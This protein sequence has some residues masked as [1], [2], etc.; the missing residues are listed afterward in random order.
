MGTIELNFAADKGML[1]ELPGDL[2]VV[3][4]SKDLAGLEESSA[5]RNLARTTLVPLEADAE[6]PRE[7]VAKAKVLVVEV[8]PAVPASVRRVS[9]IRTEHKDLRIIAAMGRADVSLVRTLIRQGIS[10]V[11]SLPFDGDEL[12][13]QLLEAMAPL[14]RKALDPSL[15]TIVTVVRSVGGCG[16]TT[17]ATHLA[18]A[19]AEEDSGGKGVCLLD[20]DI[21]CGAVASYL[22]LSPKVNVSA[23]L[24]ASD[25][26][27]DELL[28]SVVVD[29]GNGFSVIAAP[30]VITPLDGIG[31]DQLG[32]LMA[33]LRKTFSHVIVD[34]P[35]DWTNWA[36]SLAVDSGTILLVTDISI[37]G[38]RQARRRLDLLSS[39]GIDPNAIKV[40]ANRMERRFFKTIGVDDVAQALHCEVAAALDDEG[41]ALRSAQD[42]GVLV[43]DAAGKT[44]FGQQVRALALTLRNGGE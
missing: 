39:V 20:L 6:L 26:L 24:E 38:L 30:D 4:N 42:Q 10:D 34:L 36:L 19:V 31:Q 40:V 15:A 25:R 21:Q 17:L 13:T 5:F 8:D 7:L 35:A 29:S 3:A 16:A 28:R 18:A 43:W 12:V 33:L 23:L 2:C 22:G 1:F 14:R 37:S 41:A 44:R 32:K 9:Q 27:D 11:A